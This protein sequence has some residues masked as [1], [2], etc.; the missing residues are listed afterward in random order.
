M[1]NKSRVLVFF[2]SVKAAR[3]AAAEFSGWNFEESD[4]K[5]VSQFAESA[6]FREKRRYKGGLAVQLGEEGKH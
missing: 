2:T 6:N 5:Q 4:K 1:D 3:R